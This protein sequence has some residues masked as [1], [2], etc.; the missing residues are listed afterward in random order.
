[1]SY[2]VLFAGQ[3][4]QHPAMLP[5]LESEPASAGLL[6]DM[7]ARLGA[8]WREQL[9]D[10]MR[11]SDNAFAQLLITGTSLAAWAALQPFLHVRPLVVAG[12]SVGELAAFACADVFSAQQ[13]LDLAQQRAAAM[14]LA[15]LGVDTGL[16]SVSGLA[17]ASALRACAGLNLECAIRV[18]ETHS[19]LAGSNRALEQAL[20]LLL[21]QGAHCTRL[22][23]RLASHSS[24]M[25]AAV[26][27]FALALQGLRFNPPACP[28]AVN[29]LGALSRQPEELRQALSRQLACT[30]QWSS[31]LQTVAERQ[32]D[33][34]IEIGAGSALSRMWNERYPAIAARALE[35]F[36]NPSA[37]AQW[38]A[39]RSAS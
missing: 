16:L 32:P 2:A 18:S 23:V 38:I 5:W 7:V 33:C 20:P 21:A 14:D 4:S 22:A 37:A 8:D 34:V 15:V 9:Q 1:M 10:P 24:W 12:Y 13:A 28:L 19:I 35:D 39:Q 27:P 17:E 3:A 6:N 26:G 31:C 30:V 29:A 11:A 25:A 36:R